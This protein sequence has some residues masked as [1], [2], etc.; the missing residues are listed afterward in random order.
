MNMEF[1]IR[2][3]RGCLRAAVRRGDKVT[4]KRLTR[5]VVQMMGI[6]C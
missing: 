2:F 4:A 3:L 1:R 5:R 6:S